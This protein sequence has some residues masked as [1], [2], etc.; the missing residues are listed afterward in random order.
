MIEVYEEHVR[1]GIVPTGHVKAPSGDFVFSDSVSSL[2]KKAIA[3]VLS[4]VKKKLRCAYKQENLRLVF[5]RN[6]EFEIATYCGLPYFAFYHA[7]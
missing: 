7:R 1:L 2:V 4:L 3:P 6:R 5:G